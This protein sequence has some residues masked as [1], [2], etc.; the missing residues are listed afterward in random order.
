MHQTLALNVYFQISLNKISEKHWKD[1]RSRASHSGICQ[2]YLQI[3]FN[4]RPRNWSFAAR[5][6]TSKLEWTDEKGVT[7]R[8]SLK[9][10]RWGK[11]SNLPFQVSTF[12]DDPF[13]CRYRMLHLFWCEAFPDSTGQFWPS[14][15]V[16]GTCF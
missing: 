15:P 16:W 8:L 14:L 12:S 10:A 11:N 1:P 3:T 2:Y 13:S 5:V 9:L 7:K 4:L 6:M